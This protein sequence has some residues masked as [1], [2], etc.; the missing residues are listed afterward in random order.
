MVIKEAPHAWLFPK[1]CALIHHGGAGTTNTA[2]VSGRPQII[3]PVAFDQTF[4]GIA[5]WEAGLGPRPFEKSVTEITADFL[6][7]ALR[8]ALAERVVRHAAQVGESARKLHETATLR[9]AEFVEAHAPSK[10][11]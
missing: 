1:C 7:T 3:V 2:L 8:D 5:I 9:A 4:H 6:E 11:R 10:L